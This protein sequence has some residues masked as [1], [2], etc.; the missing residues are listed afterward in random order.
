M[1]LADKHRDFLEQQQQLTNSSNN[2]HTNNGGNSSGGYAGGY[3]GSVKEEPEEEEGGA[4]GGGNMLMDTA[5]QFHY[6]Q[7]QDSVAGDYE[8]SCYDNEVSRDAFSHSGDSLYDTNQS[9]PFESAG[10]L[11]SSTKDCEVLERGDIIVEKMNI[12]YGKKNL[13]PVDSMRFFPKGADAATHVAK[14][15]A[16]AVYQTV[17]PRTFEELAVRVFCR[18]VKKQRSALAAFGLFCEKQHTSCPFPT[19]SQS[20]DLEEVDVD[21]SEDV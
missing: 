1:V 20:E 2:S 11:T 12:H 16:E 14:K 8:Y 4:E 3:L 7:S 17:L 21:S 15:V 10:N 9:N 19:Q 6:M 13:N 5:D 18:N